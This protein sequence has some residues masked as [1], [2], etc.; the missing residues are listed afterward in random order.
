MAKLS[1]HMAEQIF[2]DAG[3]ELLDTYVNNNSLLLYK[4]KCGTV[5]NIRLAQFQQGHR[6][7]QCGQAKRREKCSPTQEFLEHYFKQQGC[8]L[9]STYIN[10]RTK[11]KYRCSCGN[12]AYIKW[13][14]FKGGTRCQLCGSEKNGRAHAASK[15]SFWNPDR[16]QVRINS[17]IHDRVKGM[18][19][20]CLQAFDTDKSGHAHEILGYSAQ[21]L[22]AHLCCFP[23]FE[24]LQRGDW[25]I[26]HILPVKAFVDHGISDL[27]IINALANLRPLS[28]SENHSKNAWYDEDAFISY[29]I[30]HGL[31]VQRRK[32]Q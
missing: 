30:R 29:C 13:N 18:L 32:V 11:V 24:Q 5:T 31:N 1:Q 26:D 23:N 27:S 25:H 10:T 4:C 9:L 7:K 17:L 3:C 16:E 15:C 28:A 8:I 19:R 21:E 12:T 22:W 14:D 2:K 20:A 6:C